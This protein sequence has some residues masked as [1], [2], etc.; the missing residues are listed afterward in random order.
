MSDQPCFCEKISTRVKTRPELEKALKLAYDIKEAPPNRRSSSPSTNSSTRT[1]R[2]PELEAAVKLAGEIRF[3][4]VAVTL[5]VHEHKRL[6]RGIELAMLAEELKAGDIGLEFLT[7]ELKGLHDP[8]G[9]VFTVLA[10][11]SGMERE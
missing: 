10:A 11:M 3:S 6:G 1:T 2:R 4:G 7:G 9:I 8:S 5:V